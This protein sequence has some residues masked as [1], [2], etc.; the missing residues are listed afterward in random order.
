MREIDKIKFISGTIT[1]LGKAI[2]VLGF[3]SYFFEKFPVVWRIVISCS[4]ILFI[5]MGILIY[6]ERGKGD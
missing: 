5:F 2:F 6:P 4:S 1:D 3:A